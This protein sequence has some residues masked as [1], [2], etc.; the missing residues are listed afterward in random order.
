MVEVSE[1]HWTEE[2]FIENPLLFIP[3]LLGRLEK[4]EDEARRLKAIFERLGVDGGGLILDI[5]CG[6]GRHSV[7]L[8]KHGYTVVGLDVSEAYI[9]KAREIARESGV[10]DRCEFKVGDMRRLREALGSHA[11]GFD[12]VICMFTSLG[13]FDSETDRD[14]LRQARDLSKGEGVLVVEMM[15]R[16]Y[17]AQNLTRR[18]FTEG[19]GLLR[20]EESVFDPESSRL[21]AVWRVYR[22]RGLDLEYV[23]SVRF[24]N[25]LYSASELEGLAGSAGWSDN[26]VYGGLD[27]S[28]FEPGSKRAVL[29]A[30][31][32]E[33]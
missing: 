33:A 11:G 18:R 15:S 9:D 8:A 7:A 24:D 14:V 6:V 19:G 28:D 26:R 5:A 17:A 1:R 16:G 23:G 2:T 3:E 12:A 27:L 25:R 32:L 30:R 29:V 31:R 22:P 20:L 13:Y 4:A 21:R 10:S